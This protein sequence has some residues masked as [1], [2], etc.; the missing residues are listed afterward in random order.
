MTVGEVLDLKAFLSQAEIEGIQSW[1]SDDAE[2]AAV[3]SKGVVTAAQPGETAVM[4]T[5]ED[6]E[7]IEFAITVREDGIILLDLGEGDLALNLDEYIPG[8]VIGNM[9][10]NIEITE[11]AG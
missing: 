2:I 3:T 11:V 1:S 4:A 5:L 8:N 6:G 7:A 10:T 9:E